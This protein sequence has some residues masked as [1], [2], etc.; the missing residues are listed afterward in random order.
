MGPGKF[1]LPLDGPSLNRLQ[2]NRLCKSNDKTPAIGINATLWELRT[3]AVNS[4]DGRLSSSGNHQRSN[5][6]L[7]TLRAG[8]TLNRALFRKN[9]GAPGPLIQ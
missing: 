6:V 9:V 7:H 8:F 4:S 3:H 1:P 2:K 5:A